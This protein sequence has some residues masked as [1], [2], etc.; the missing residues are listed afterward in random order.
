[1]PAALT[2]VERAISLGARKA[3]AFRTWGVVE[4]IN[5]DWGKALTRL[6]EAVNAS[7]SDAE[8]LRRL[9]VVQTM[10]GNTDDALHTVLAALEV[11]PLNA[12][13]HVTAG[14]IQQ[15]RGEFAEAEAQYQQALAEDRNH[16]EAAEFHAE[17]LVYLQRTDDALASVTDIAARLRTDPVAYYRLGRI[18]QAGGRPRAEWMSTFERSRAI[19]EE[20]LKARPMCYGPRLCPHADAPRRFRDAVAAQQRALTLARRFPR[21]TT[22]HECMRFSGQAKAMV[23]LT[24]AIDLP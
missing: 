13:L 5:G 11:D 3:E 19:L 14:L 20:D 4:L 6:E 1:M 23:N 24:Q 7:P 8:A 12:D 22:A 17:I 16:T 21:C 9:A 18:A 15:F 2:C 10:R